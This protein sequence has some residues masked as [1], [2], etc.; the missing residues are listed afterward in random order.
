MTKRIEFIDIAKGICILML[1]LQ[2]AHTYYSNVD[3]L[4]QYTVSFRV[5][6]FFFVSGCFFKLYGSFKEFCIKKVN[7]LLIPFFFFYLVFSVALPNLLFLIGYE[8]LRQSQSLGWH[9]LLNFWSGTAHQY[10][11]NPVWFLIALFNLSFIFYFIRVFSIVNHRPI[12]LTVILSILVGLIGVT[13]GEYRI[14]P[15]MHID[16]AFTACP[17]FCFGYL[18]NNE[19]KILKKSIR[20]IY[21]C[22]CI[23]ICVLVVYLFS[24]GIDYLGNGFSYKNI[25]QAYLSGIAGSLVIIMLAYIIGHSKVL[26]FYGRNTLI[27]L[28]MQM[29]VLQ[30]LNLVLKKITPGVGYFELFLLFILAM[31][32]MVIII[33][34]YNKYLP[35]AVGKKSIFKLRSM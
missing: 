1:L 27:V 26:C 9:S 28:C 12:L 35:F 8:G 16:N 22:I 33:K 13:C 21:I 23:C 32:S 2:H 6:L 25:L 15:P 4:E 30:P 19:T 20:H 11:N 18:L 14:H 5:P 3:I 10:S 17:Y 29:P 24:P 31:L 7:T 34:F